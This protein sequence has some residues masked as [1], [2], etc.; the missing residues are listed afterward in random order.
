MHA[1]LL[2][3][4]LGTRFRPH[5]D[6]IAKPAIPF[7]NLPLISYPLYH[8]KTLGLKNLIVNLHHKPDSIK[9]ALNSVAPKPQFKLNFLIEEPEIL[10]SGGGLLNAKDLLKDAEHFFVINADEFF[11]FKSRRALQ[12]V[13]ETHIKNKAL[14]TLLTTEHEE[15]G[16]SFGGVNISKDSLI[17]ELSVRTRSHNTKHFTGVFVFSR[18]IFNFMPNKKVFHIF[19]D[20][21]KPAIQ[22]KEKLMAYH[23]PDMLWLDMSGENEYLK[24]TKTMLKELKENSLWGSE[25]ENIFRHYHIH[26]HKNLKNIWYQ[27]GAKVSLSVDDASFAL[28]GKDAV[29]NKSVEVK[30]LSVFGDHVVYDQGV[31]ESS[32][33]GPCVHMHELVAL[34]QQLLLESVWRV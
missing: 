11:L 13:L 12:D 9:M 18:A 6:K 3:A 21:L 19:D 25:L 16:L 22:R 8:L 28:V 23:D 14:A 1:M 26:Y 15:A 33:I 17:S 24:A 4:G 29:I 10:S 34:R 30:G 2:A 32:V 27:D 31:V 7:L 20:C 5:T